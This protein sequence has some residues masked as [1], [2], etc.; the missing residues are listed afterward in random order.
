MGPDKIPLVAYSSSFSSVDIPDALDM[1]VWLYSEWQQ[2]N[3]INTDWKLDIQKAYDVTIED[4]LDLEQIYTDNDPD[5]F[6]KNSL[7]KRGVARRF[8]RAVS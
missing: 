8:I 1:A 6:I 7:K 4:A 2:S 5:F 3:I